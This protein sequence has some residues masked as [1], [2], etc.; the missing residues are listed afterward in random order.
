MS[1]RPVNERR[2]YDNTGREKQAKATRGRIL[3]A[4]H[5]VLL[6]RGYAATTMAL[7]ATEAE[8]SV[9]TLYKGF[10]TK[11][12]LIRQ[13][14]GAALVGDDDPI[15]LAQRPEAH[16][17]AAET[18]GEAML[19]RYAAWCRQ[20]YDRLGALPAILLIGARSGE[21]D[22]QAFATSVKNKRL[23]D[24]VTA[25][26]QLATTGDLR[27]EIDRDHARDPIWALNSPEMHQLLTVDRQWS[28]QHYEQW[29]AQALIHALLAPSASRTRLPQ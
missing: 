1:G 19:T 20:L 9:E 23:I 7:I 4:A 11:P 8:V 16:A 26:D 14:L 12:E 3:D 5:R 18:S 17:I 24:S 21:P 6:E 22:L 25:A 29:L 10:K 28:G 2:R 15:P 13:M 27:P